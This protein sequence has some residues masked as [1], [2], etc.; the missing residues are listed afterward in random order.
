MVDARAVGAV[1]AARGV[2]RRRAQNNAMLSFL[3]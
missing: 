2:E 3:R 1:A